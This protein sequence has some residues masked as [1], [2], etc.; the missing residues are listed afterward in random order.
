VFSLRAD[1]TV[2]VQ[3][4][5]EVLFNEVAQVIDSARG[6]GADRVGLMS[7]QIATRK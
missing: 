7:R 2:F 5:D 6:A 4:D 1:R 3:A